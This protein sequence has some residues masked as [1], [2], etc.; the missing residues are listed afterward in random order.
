VPF[1]LITIKN[2]FEGDPR[3]LREPALL[4]GA[5]ASQYIRWILI[6]LSRPII[7]TAM[8]LAFLG[9]WNGFTAPLILLTDEALY[10]VSLKL[11]SYVGS[12]AFGNPRWNLFAA[13]SV[14]NLLFIRLL[15]GNR[16]EK[17]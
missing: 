14:L 8:I 4:E 11:Y 16:F 13:A 15:G 7:K 3:E 17:A 12:I 2:F 1:A 5:T 6:P 9:A 10:P